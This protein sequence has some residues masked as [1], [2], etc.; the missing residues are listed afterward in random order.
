MR[1]K[2]VPNGEGGVRVMEMIE[3]IPALGPVTAS[4]RL[5]SAPSRAYDAITGEDIAFTYT[6]GRAG[7]TVPSLRIHAAVV[8][9]GAA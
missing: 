1:G 8:F 4:V 6:D 3:D 9:E 5:P 7:V 2:A